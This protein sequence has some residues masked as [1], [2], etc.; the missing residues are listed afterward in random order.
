MENLKEMKQ[1]LKE[2][3][4]AIRA[5]K[6]EIKNSMRKCEFGNIWRLQSA[7]ESA[8]CTYRTNHIAYSMARGKSY[9]QIESKTPRAGEPYWSLIN[10]IIEQIKPQLEEAS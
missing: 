4:K 5:L 8:K 3:G 10:E 6:L 7:V 9:D 1:W 2:N